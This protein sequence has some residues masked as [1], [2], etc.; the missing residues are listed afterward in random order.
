LK[1]KWLRY[2]NIGKNA[3][4]ISLS[5]NAAHSLSG[6]AAHSLSGNAAQCDRG[7]AARQNM[8]TVRLSC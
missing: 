2:D 1:P 3:V 5:G 7:N 6:N 8:E 4:I